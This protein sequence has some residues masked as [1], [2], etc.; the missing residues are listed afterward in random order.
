MSAGQAVA[1]LVIAKD[2]R[3]LHRL[4]ADGT[5]RIA[6]LRS[7]YDPDPLPEI[8]SHRMRLALCLV[9]GRCPTAEAVRVAEAHAQPPAAIP[10]TTHAGPLPGRLDVVAVDDA[11]VVATQLKRAADGD[12][13]VVRLVNLDGTARTV[14]LQLAPALGRVRSARACDLHEQP[15]GGDLLDD[16]GIAVPVPAHGLATVRIGFG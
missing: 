16:A 5:Q 14:R 3:C 4:D 13:L 10:T 8:G 7:S 9:A 6:L 2:G 15:T 1:G 11:A 12:D